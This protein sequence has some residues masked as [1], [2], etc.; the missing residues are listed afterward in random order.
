MRYKVLWFSE[1]TLKNE[2]SNG[3]VG[4]V[5]ISALGC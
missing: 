5:S 4:R 2:V 1:K 3:N